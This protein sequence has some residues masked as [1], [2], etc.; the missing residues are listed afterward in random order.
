[1]A[2]YRRAELACARV[3]RLSSR[4]PSGFTLFELLIVMSLMAIFAGI[5]LGGIN[6]LPFEIREASRELAADLQYASQ[7]A[8]ATGDLHRWIVDLDDQRYRLERLHDA[9]PEQTGFGAPTHAGLLDLRAPADESEFRAVENRSGEWRWLDQDGV[10]ID[11]VNVGDDDGTS[12]L[13]AIRFVPDGGSDPAE[14]LI[15]DASGRRMR[16]RI[17]AFTSEVRIDEQ[18]DG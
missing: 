15:E 3:E 17:L 11:R 13:V 14:V 4:S 7:R 16:L 10:W 8:I 1:L 5:Y 6:A 2:R 9:E 18:P 12:G